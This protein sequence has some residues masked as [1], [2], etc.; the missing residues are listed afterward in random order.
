MEPDAPLSDVKING[1]GIVCWAAFLAAGIFIA[2][3]D[4]ALATGFAT[5]VSSF[6]ALVLVVLVFLQDGILWLG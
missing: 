2:A 4:F 1:V 6:F 3:A 5:V